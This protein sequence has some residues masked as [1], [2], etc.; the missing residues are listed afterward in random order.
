ML[1]VG[2]LVASVSLVGVPQIHAE[3]QIYQS[4]ILDSYPIKLD[5]AITDGWT[6]PSVPTEG[7]LVIFY[8]QMRILRAEIYQENMEPYAMPFYRVSAVVRCFL[9]GNSL[10]NGTYVFLEDLVQ[11]AYSQVP[12]RAVQGEHI[13]TWIVDP[14]PYGDLN[15]ENNVLQYSF[16]VGEP[17]RDLDFSISASPNWQVTKIGESASY[18]VNAYM[19]KAKPVSFALQGTSGCR[20]SF[21]RAWVNSSESSK[22]SILC[23]GASPGAYYL[24]LTASGQNKSHWLTL[25]LILVG[26]SSSIS[27]FVSPESP[28]LG[29][30]LTIR[31]TISPP[32]EATVTLRY[33]RPEGPT[34]TVSMRT[35]SD[36]NFEYNI[37][38]DAPGLWTFSV[39]CYGDMNYGGAESRLATITV[40]EPQVSPVAEFFKQL[41]NMPT[42]ILNAVA[43]VLLT[44]L[45]VALLFAFVAVGRTRALHRVS[46]TA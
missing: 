3:Q 40:R 14:Q 36:G 20:Y 30:N 34:P 15:L 46:N 25:V 43:S 1:V 27:I 37:K 33:S 9:D 28:T 39:I 17:S 35:R 23:R 31:G 44:V 19:T 6:A 2:V 4:R 42:N 38:T 32:H 13:V 18:Q 24:N 5:F 16:G 22:L 12:W 29:E 26:E 41:A 21:S 10:W 7:D 11:V 45:V 8:A